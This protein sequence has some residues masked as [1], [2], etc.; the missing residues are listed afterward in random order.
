MTRSV[1]VH[2]HSTR[3]TR[4]DCAETLF[5]YLLVGGSAEAILA[6][7]CSAIHSSKPRT[8][9]RCSLPTPDGKGQVLA[10]VAHPPGVPRRP[11]RWPDCRACEPLK[12]SRPNGQNFLLRG[13]NLSLFPSGDDL[14]WINS[15]LE[16]LGFTAV[17]HGDKATYGRL[18]LSHRVEDHPPQTACRQLREE[19]L[20]RI[21]PSGV[22]GHDEPPERGVRVLNP[23]C[24]MISLSLI[25]TV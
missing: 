4:S 25:G 22:L 14:V 18:T 2:C 20:H 19:P 5:H 23:A 11:T 16:R 10:V 9:K 3:S 7:R 1:P 8:E 24:P 13:M 6:A 12:Y 15:P 21:Q 17:V